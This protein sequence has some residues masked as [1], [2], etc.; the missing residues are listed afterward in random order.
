M[1]STAEIRGW[2]RDNGYDPPV[3]GRI[4][5][6]L[7]AAYDAAHPS[8]NG[9]A[10]MT[11]DYPDEDFESAFA[12][13]PPAEGPQDTGETPPKKP[14]ANRGRTGGGKSSRWPWGSKKPGGNK[15]PRVSTEDLLGSVW[16]GMA[17][18]T[19][20]LPPLQRTLRVQAPVAGLLLEDAVRDTAMDTVLQP[21][22]RLA[23][24]GKTVSA[25]LGPPVIVTAITL[26]AQQ[27]QAEG[28]APNPVFMGVATEALRSSLMTWMDVAGPKFEVAMAREREFEDK[29]GK[30]V[31]DF[32]NW[33]FSDPVNPADQAA[34]EAEED[35]IRRAQ[36][37]L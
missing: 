18:L 3:K 8:G 31:D 21:L 30:S 13:P 26:H 37:I 20:P 12:D 6:N 23:N 35:A 28:H 25:L 7:Q 29:Y 14:R 1:P 9:T 2:L 10:T 33:L 24:Q 4:D 36:G 27:R 16:R 34:M 22:A 17:K 15:K 19:T 5:A 11:G 32:M